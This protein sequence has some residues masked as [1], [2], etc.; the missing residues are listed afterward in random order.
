MKQLFLA[1]ALLVASMP[2]FADAIFT[3]GNH[4][5]GEENILFHPDMTGMTI[6][7]IT[8]QSRTDVEFSS[9]DVLV[10]KGGQ[11]D[12][13]AQDGLI[14]N[15]TF[16][17]P[18]HTFGDFIINPFKP[19]QNSDLLVMVTTN[20][21]IFDFTYGSKKGDNFLTITTTAGDA[22]D[23]V[24]IDSVKGFEDLKQPRVSAI[25]GV[26]T[27]EPS[28]LALLGSGI[29]GLAATLRRKLV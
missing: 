17:I 5:S 29:L 15:I 3:P 9:T 12:I 22:I 8:N 11:A 19:T 20:E 13:A 28:S 24:T 23:S 6:Q 1:L 4:K 16:A 14:Y 27:P 7:G 21:G 25:S 2:A 10:G 26:P 18:G